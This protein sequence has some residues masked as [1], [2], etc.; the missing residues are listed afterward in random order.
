MRP[1]QVSSA[2][3]CRNRLQRPVT[4]VTTLAFGVAGCTRAHILHVGDAS[5]KTLQ[6]SARGDLM[7]KRARVH[8]GEGEPMTLSDLMQPV[9]E[10]PKMCG[11]YFLFEC[12]EIV[13]IGQSVRVYRRVSDHRF[14]HDRV[15]WFPVAEDDLLAYEGAL[16]RHFKPKHNSA[17]SAARSRDKEIVEGL[18]LKYTP[19]IAEPAVVVD[20]PAGATFGEILHA[21][22]KANGK[23]QSDIAAVIGTS[24]GMVSR[25]E[26]DEALP[27]NLLKVATAYE[28]DRE[29]LTAAYFASRA[30]REQPAV[31]K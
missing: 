18:G 13:Y 14:P 15:A 16:I 10:A 9:P 24:Q 6:K 19:P 12:D 17:S 2:P 28:C 23:S 22:R 3:W 31:R 30:R 4:P 26:S 25:W 21:A 20:I 1:A 5:E 11:V 27:R 8:D 29:N 7:A